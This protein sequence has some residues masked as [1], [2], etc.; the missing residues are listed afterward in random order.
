MDEIVLTASTGR[1]TGTRTSRRVRR[2]G[3]VPGVLYGLEAE[4]VTIAVD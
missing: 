2:D 1:A 3:R 4:S